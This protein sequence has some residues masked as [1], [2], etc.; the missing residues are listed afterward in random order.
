MKKNA[1][2][3][4]IMV[5]GMAAFVSVFVMILL[6][7]LRST[8]GGGP[9]SSKSVEDAEARGKTVSDQFTMDVANAEITVYYD[10]INSALVCV[11]KN[12][13]VFTWLNNKTA[14]IY[15]AAMTYSAEADTD[16]KKVEEAKTKIKEFFVEVKEGQADPYASVRSS[17]QTLATNFK[18]FF[19][20]EQENEAVLTLRV[21]YTDAEGKKKV[22]PDKVVTQPYSDGTKTYRAAHPQE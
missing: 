21:N 15:R 7:V 11:S 10:K 6:I 12:Q 18:A 22:L 20:A 16:E 2:I 9:A 17:A 5:T 1:G 14:S 3:S 13:F 8:I 4:T 19:V